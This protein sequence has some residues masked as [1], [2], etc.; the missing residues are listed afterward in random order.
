MTIQD[1]DAPIIADTELASC[2]DPNPQTLPA[3]DD[4]SSDEVPFKDD[5]PGYVDDTTGYAWDAWDTV[6][7][8]AMRRHDDLLA[9]SVEELEA[10]DLEALDD[11]QRLAASRAWR[12]HDYEE[13]SLDALGRIARSDMEHPAIRYD[14]VRAHLV[15]RELRRGALTR[16]GQALG[17]LAQRD[18]EHHML[19]RLEALH[20]ALGG[21]SQKASELIREGLRERPDDPELRYD[22]AKELADFG[23]T[24]WSKAYLKQARL[25]AERTGKRSVL[26]DVALLEGELP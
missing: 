5:Y 23:Y 1:H 3:H 11:L 20:T 9:S 24:G 4:T 16:A 22:V 7:A 15:E 13:E 6:T 17:E 10:L 26:V 25:V 19:W 2:E 18:P 8:R 12:A 21:D 14:E